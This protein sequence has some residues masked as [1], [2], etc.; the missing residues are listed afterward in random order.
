M[1]STDLEN[2]I[3][4]YGKEVYSFCMYL[5]KDKYDADDLYQNTFLTVYEKGDIDLSG[6]PKSYIIT[7]AANLW[8]NQWRKTVWRKKKADI[9]P[10][11]DEMLENISDHRGTVESE[12]E[13]KEESE[14][15]RKVVRSLPDKLRSVILMYYMEEMSIEDIALALA[16]PAGTVKSRM[17]K[18][19]KMLKEKLK[20]E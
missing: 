15:V 13:R 16:I 9:V 19:K 10:I 17:H 6:N 11:Q 7:I 18:A 14:M 8:N 5:A 12:Y 3:A 1:K 4:E 20:Y 2:L